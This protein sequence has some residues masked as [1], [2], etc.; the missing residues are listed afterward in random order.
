MAA[1]TIAI[2]FIVN[3]EDV[4]VHAELAE[5]LAAARNKALAETRN[6]GRPPDEWE[7][8][9][10]TGVLLDPSLPMTDF[11]FRPGVRLFLSLR[12]GAGGCGAG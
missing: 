3:G 8:R 11:Q 2:L 10:E 6:T 5:P 4:I 1:G 12:V 9:D 7:V